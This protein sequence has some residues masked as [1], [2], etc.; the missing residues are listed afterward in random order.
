M[1]AATAA[2]F[3]DSFEDS[4]LGEV[5]RG[6][7][8]APFGE[9]LTVV[10]GK[11]YQ[12][13]ELQPSSTALVTLKSFHRGGGYRDDGLK[14]FVGKYK[15]QQ[16]VTPGELIVAFTDVTQAADVIGKPA[17]V[18]AS[19]AHTTL[20]ASLDVGIVRPHAEPLTR[21]YLYLYM[22][23]NAFQE[24][25]YAHANGSTVLHLASQAVEQFPGLWPDVG[26]AHAFRASVAPLFA[27]D[28]AARQE[29][30]SLAT[31]RDYLLPKLLSG[32]VRVRD[33]EKVV[34]EAL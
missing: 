14:P 3:P 28:A 33:A 20:V 19:N 15:P 22:L 16:V 11:S 27:R 12:S 10:K 1:D 25:T 6:W 26:V 13:A 7:R 24:H 30:Q 2:L 32:E 8:V 21:E 17:I 5:P 18:R 9:G 34:G 23:G 29:S 31:L 4:E